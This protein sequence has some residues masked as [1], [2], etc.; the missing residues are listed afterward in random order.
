MIDHVEA[1]RA[2]MK[3]A[4][5]RIDTL[6]QAERDFVWASA[7]VERSLL[8]RLPDVDPEDLKN[9]WAAIVRQAK[10][11]SH[12]T[13]QREELSV[14]EHMGLILRHLRDCGGFVEFVDLFDTTQGVP[15]LVVHFLAM[16]ELAREHLLVI[17]QSEAFAPIYV[18]L[19]DGRDEPAA[20]DGTVAGSERADDRDVAR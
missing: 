2:Q 4:A 9:A 13:I 6:P 1:R 15:V 10:L 8:Q 12:H 7:L 17:T 5:V 14:R 20:G 18:R 11:H 16:L 3:L 19:A